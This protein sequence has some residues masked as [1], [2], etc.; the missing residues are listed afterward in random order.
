MAVAAGRYRAERCGLTNDEVTQDRPESK[1]PGYDVKWETVRVGSRDYT[2][3]SLLDKQQYFDPEGIAEARG[4]APAH[5]ALFGQVWGSSLLLAEYM[6][7]YS[8]SGQRVLELGCGL[9]L[10]GLVLHARIADVVVSDWHPECESFLRENLRL[11][12]LGPLRFEDIDWTGTNS[13]LGTFD[14]IIGSD[15]I[16]EPE[17]PTQLIEFFERHGS[18]AFEVILVGPRRRP[19]GTMAQKLLEHGFSRSEKSISAQGHHL[20][21]YYRR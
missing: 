16:Y 10:P 20:V 1:P 17:H 11:N 6:S 2:I 21:H 15:I 19:T 5:W 8:L 9:A 4:I 12:G 18:Q 13:Q 3:R 14:V 7:S